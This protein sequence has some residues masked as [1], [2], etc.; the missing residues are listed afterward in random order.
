VVPNLN[1]YQ[2]NDLSIDGLKL[3]AD[4]R[5]ETTQRDVVPRALSGV[6]ARFSVTR[7]AAASLILHGP[8][9]KVLPVGTRVRDTQTG[10]EYRGGLTLCLVMSM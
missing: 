10:A 8:D 7:Y 4:A 5:I 6:T 9:G 1:S 3:P 2:H